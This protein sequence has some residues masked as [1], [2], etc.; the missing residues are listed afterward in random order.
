MITHIVCWR[1]KS[2][3]S[4]SKEEN[5]ERIKEI[6]EALS[7]KIDELITLEVGV[8]FNDSPAAYDVSLYTTFNTKEDLEA[9]Q[10]HPDH[11]KAASFVKSVVTERVVVDYKS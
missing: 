1:V 6:L 8:N 7:T 4:A 2:T 3:D 11:V 10:I 5:M 9:Y